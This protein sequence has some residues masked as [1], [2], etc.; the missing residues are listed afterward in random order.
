MRKIS[1]LML[2]VT[3][4][5]ALAACH[6]AQYNLN[7]NT[8][9]NE[10]PKPSNEVNTVSPSQTTE[11]ETQ[12]SSSVRGESSTEE[13]TGIPI[14]GTKSDSYWIE[15]IVNSY[16]E[17]IT[18]AINKNDFS[19]IEHLLLPDSNIYQAQENFV[20]E[21]YGKGIKYKYIDSKL[22][23]YERENQKNDYKAYVSANIEISEPNKDKVIKAFKRIYTIIIGE[24]TKRIIDIQEWKDK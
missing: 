22:E 7:S 18:D 9:Q 19:K 5:I 24:K 1:S 4:I 20:V 15:E 6:S 16:E 23:D 14:E 13:S 21:Q 12:N 17:L 8:K 2:A 3:M 11:P 10:L